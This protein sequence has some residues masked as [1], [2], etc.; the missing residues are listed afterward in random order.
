[1][2]IKWKEEVP[3]ACAVL[4]LVRH[5]ERVES[6]GRKMGSN[7]MPAYLH[8]DPQILFQ[9]QYRDKTYQVGWRYFGQIGWH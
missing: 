8:T 5:L 9:V 4:A 3:P 1:M 6:M 2:L 7:I